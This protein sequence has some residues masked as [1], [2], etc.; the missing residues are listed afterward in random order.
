MPDRFKY[1]TFRDELMDDP[2]V[3]ADLLRKNLGELDKLNRYTL[4][5]RPGIRALENL[6]D[7]HSGELHIADL[8][9]GSG[10]ALKYMAKW[11][12]KK[13]I[14]ARFTGID[15]S[16]HAIDYLHEHCSDYPEI[17]G[18][19][20]TH[21][22]FLELGEGVDVYHCSLF[23]H[24]LGDEEALDLLLHFKSHARLGFVV[25]DILR[26]PIAYYGSVIIPH[27]AFGTR[28]A[29]HDGPVS[30]LRGFRMDEVRDMLARAGISAYELRRSMGF[31][32]ILAAGTGSRI[33]HDAERPKG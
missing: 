33:V 32:F 1:R 7:G 30:V 20:M 22:E 12:R 23:M 27:L 6:L 21:K 18:L 10:D 2:D 29:R 13:G 19:A 17:R 28:L 26:G 8:G 3:P 16:P 9:C 25:S 11:A 24:H 14:R 4:A 31:R 5:Y 15:S